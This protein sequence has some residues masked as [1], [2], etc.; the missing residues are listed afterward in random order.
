MSSTLKV[1]KFLDQSGDTQFPRDLSLDEAKER[2]ENTVG[3]GTHF[4]MR[5]EEGRGK[6]IDKFEDA[7]EDTLV[8][9]M[10]QGG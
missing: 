2:F 10:L 4:A 3:R 9:P 1:M 7:G 5:M 8:A 6:R